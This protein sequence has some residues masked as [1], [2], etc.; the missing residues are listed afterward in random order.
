MKLLDVNYE[1]AQLPDMPENP[2]LEIRRSLV[3]FTSQVRSMLDGQQ[4]MPLLNGIIQ[5]FQED[6]GNLK[7][8]YRV[9]VESFSNG[10][11]G[12][13]S[14]RS[15][16]TDS[17]GRIDLTQVDNDDVSS[18][19]GAASPALGFASVPPSGASMPRRRQHSLFLDG[20]ADIAGPGTP[21]KRARGINGSVKQ[22]DQSEYG[23]DSPAFGAGARRVLFT[24]SGQ[25]GTQAADQQ[26]QARSLQTVRD[27]ID[28]RM[29]PGMPNIVTED[30]YNSLSME[31]IRP[32]MDPLQQMLERVYHLLDAKLHELLSN[33]L[34]NLRKRLI[35]KHA[36]SALKKFLVD[37]M[38]EV[39]TTLMQHYQLETRKY[40][41]LDREALARNEEAERTLLT[42]HRHYYRMVTY[43]GEQR[44]KERPIPKDWEAMSD[45]ERIRDKSMMNQELA[46]LGPDEYTREVGV[47]ANVRG[48]YR[49]AATR[50]VDTCTMHI[51]SG[52]LPDVT[53][54]LSKSYLDNQ[55]GVFDRTTPQTFLDLMDEDETTA[56]KR[57]SLKDDRNR[58]QLTMESIQR[59]ENSSQSSQQEQP[60]Q[61]QS[62]VPVQ[63]DGDV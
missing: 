46:K 11:A 51:S 27:I 57:A 20:Q 24:R 38:T 39:Q 33:A 29:K 16:T 53:D 58:F 62:Q 61:P 5:Q 54:Q 12:S 4:L 31:A 63:V 60:T 35:Y 3:A 50:F 52:L 26:K 21:S 14:N 45:D 8:K 28:A 47:C 30:I 34:S 44:G 48:Y 23:S 13:G 25:Q 56:Q 59:L 41:T 10:Q 19:N 2:E 43:L 49:T 40:Y 6:I 15:V 36:S 32:W 55:L 9:K 17:N 7:P 1:L 42:R 22:E 37:R 18:V